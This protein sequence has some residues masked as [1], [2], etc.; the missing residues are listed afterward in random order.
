M[1]ELERFRLDGR[2]AM[3]SG[4][5]GGIG[6][7]TCAA[8][9]GVGARV[10][11]VGRST[12]RLAKAERAVADGDSEALV[13][14]ADMASKADADQAVAKTIERFGRLDVLVN[15]IGGGAGTALYGAA[16]YPEAERD[17]IVHLNWRTTF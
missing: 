10:A 11:I 12:E 13:I 9:A 16:D 8:L 2:V 4:G 1:D 15:S 3:V 17:R 5:S 7:S 14:A 6:V